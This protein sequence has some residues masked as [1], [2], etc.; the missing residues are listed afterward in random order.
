SYGSHIFSTPVSGTSVITIKKATVA[1]H[2][3][4]T[5]WNDAFASGQASFAS[6]GCGSSGSFPGCVAWEI[7]TGFWVFDG[8]VGTGA[9]AASYGFKIPAAS[10]SSSS[11]QGIFFGC[12]G[13]KT[14]SN[15]TIQHVAVACPGP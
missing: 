4:N 15:V 6:S 2:G 12:C 13:P 14:V 7:D 8:V 1:D 5:G 11:V 10:T 9:G 3:T